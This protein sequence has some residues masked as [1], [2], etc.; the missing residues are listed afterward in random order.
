MAFGATSGLVLANGLASIMD[1]HWV[2]LIAGGPSVLLAASV[3]FM[4]IPA[5]LHLPTKLPAR[6]YVLAPTYLIALA[7]GILSTF[8]AS[9]L[10]VWSRSLI[11]EERH[12]SIWPPTSSWPGS[13]WSAASAASSRAAIWATR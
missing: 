6:A 11:V 9:A 8:G 4:A 13:G 10:V 5:R 3:A 12:I 2:F 7:G 1:W